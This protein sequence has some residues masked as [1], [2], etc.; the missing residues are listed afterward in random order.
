MFISNV[1]KLFLSKLGR[2]YCSS[3]PV[4][5]VLENLSSTRSLIRASGDEVQ[6]F[7]QGLITNDINHVARPG[8]SVAMYTLFLNKPG[9]VLYDAL[10]YNVPDEANTFYIECDRNAASE[11]RKHLTM[12]RV[13]KKIELDVVGDELSVWAAFP[14][15]E[16]VQAKK[17]GLEERSDSCRKETLLQ[18]VDPRCAALGTRIIASSTLTDIEIKSIW[19]DSSVV[20]SS[21]LDYAEHRYKLGIGEGLVEIPT[22][23]SF[24][25]EANCDFLHGISFHK[26]CYL[27]QEFTAR[28]YHTGV[29]RKRL[30]PLRLGSNST[31]VSDLPIDSPIAGGDGQSVGK[32]RGVRNQYAIGILR[33][34]QALKSEVLKIGGTEA[35]TC[36]P[37]WWPIVSGENKPPPS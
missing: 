12:F 30:M 10:I 15:E 16:S 17:V 34:E 18:F 33:V 27:G 36:R 37:S 13:R 4:P 6:P 21:K 35:T 19:P 24:P 29:I 14:L 23:K 1:R 8:K 31:V 7:L 2:G 25:F 32:L 20:E 22:G 3:R 5:V 26:G 28:T 9:R 11:L